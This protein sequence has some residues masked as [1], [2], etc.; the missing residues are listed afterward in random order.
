MNFLEIFFV[1]TFEQKKLLIII[2]MGLIVAL[3]LGFIG[4]FVKNV[5]SSRR[6]NQSLPSLVE[7]GL[8]EDEDAENVFEEEDEDFVSVFT[9]DDDEDLEADNEADQMYQE[10]RE[11][12]KRNR[13]GFFNRSK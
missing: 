9:I 10:V 12:E 4:V 6:D 8:E 5:I 7:L 13:R 1:L 3:I 11:A 2:V